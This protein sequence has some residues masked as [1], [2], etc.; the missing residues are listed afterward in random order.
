MSL[1][2]RIKNILDGEEGIDVEYKGPLKQVTPRYFV[3]FANT[4]GG[5]LLIG[6]DDK[7]RADGSQYGEIV[8]IAITDRHKVSIESKISSCIPKIEAAI[9]IETDD[10]GKS[11]YVV[12]V[13]EGKNKPYR[14]NEGLYVV[15]KNGRIDAL[16]QPL[17]KEM[18]LGEIREKNDSVSFPIVY[19][20]KSKS[21]PYWVGYRGLNDAALLVNELLKI[22]NSYETMLGYGN[23]QNENDIQRFFRDLYECLILGWLSRQH[24]WQFFFDNRPSPNVPQIYHGGRIRLK[25]IRIWDLPDIF[26]ENNIFLLVMKEKFNSQRGN[27]IMLPED[28]DLEIIHDSNNRADSTIKIY[29]PC[30]EIRFTYYNAGGFRGLDTRLPQEVYLNHEEVNELWT[31]RTGIIFNSKFHVKSEECPLIDEYKLWADQLLKNLRLHFDFDLYIEDIPNK[32]MVQIQR[33][34]EIIKTMLSKSLEKEKG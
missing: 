6:V 11:I 8:G 29:E 4:K 32:E 28:M 2:E 33:E 24:N 31:M 3:S 13:E 25:K 30:G 34:L 26:K 23:D 1:S 20:Q 5:T 27:E 12:D 7:S 22:D 16:D 9:S 15:R 19:N 18:L 17:M 10:D 21:F 14:T